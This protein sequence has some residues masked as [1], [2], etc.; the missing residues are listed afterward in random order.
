MQV[1]LVDARG[2]SR[3]C[4]RCGHHGIRQGKSFTCTN[5]ACGTRIDADLNSARN[6]QVAPLSP[7]LHANGE[8][9]RY[10]PLASATRAST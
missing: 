8:G 6:I 2:T 5:P 10:P 9:A 4:S 7:R 3:R 1:E